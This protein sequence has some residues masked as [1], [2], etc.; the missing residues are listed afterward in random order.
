MLRRII[1]AGRL[2]FCKINQ[3]IGGGI[4]K[5]EM[6]F[7]ICLIKTEIIAHPKQRLVAAKISA[8]IRIFALWKILNWKLMLD[9]C[10]K[11]LEV[12]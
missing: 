8:V 3:S 10:S 4:F 1:V 9:D 11:E 2:F 5:T 7:V 12:F 6:P